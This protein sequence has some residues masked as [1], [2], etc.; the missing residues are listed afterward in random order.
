[1]WNSS[2]AASAI[3][4]GDTPATSTWIHYT[5]IADSTAG[6]IYSYKNGTEFGTPVSYNGTIKD[7]ANT[8]YIGQNSI[9]GDYFAG[10][11]DEVEFWKNP[12]FANDT[13]REAFVT[14]LY[15]SGTGKFIDTTITKDYRKSDN[16]RLLAEVAT[17]DAALT[18]IANV[19][20]PEDRVVYIEAIIVGRKD[21]GTDRATYK[22][23]G[24]FYRNT[25]GNVTQQGATA[26]V[27]TPIE[28]NASW[29]TSLTADTGNQTIDINVQGVAATNVDWKVE[30]KWQY[31][32]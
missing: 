16:A 5:F 1:M 2:D 24:C 17:V 11:I 19:A 22:I 29:L 30:Y 10:G 7:N 32:E 27:I 6:N 26:D 8:L 4:T 21:D 12:T 18:E 15:N 20:V 9:G 28:S 23:A 25:A 3:A 13:A 31:V 14:A